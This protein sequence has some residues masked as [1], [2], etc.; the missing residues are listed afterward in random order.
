MFKGNCHGAKPECLVTVSKPYNMFYGIVSGDL[1][2]IV[3]SLL[4]SPV[5]L[6]FSDNAHYQSIPPLLQ[7]SGCKDG[8]TAAHNHRFFKLHCKTIAGKILMYPSS[9]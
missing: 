8:L 1:F 5:F 2:K 9:C 3:S 7:S 6:Y 4:F